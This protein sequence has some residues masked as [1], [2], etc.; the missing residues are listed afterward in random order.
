[1]DSSTPTKDT[2][3][4]EQ[5][6]FEDKLLLL[7]AQKNVLDVGGAG[8]FSKGLAKYSHW[9]KDSNFRSFDTPGVGA[10]IEGDIH[11]M[12]IESE[13]QDAVLCNAVL[14]HVA[15]PIRAVEEIHRILKTGGV[16]LV[17]VPSTYPYHGN[18]KYGD[19]WRFFEET[20]RY[21][22]KDFSSIEIVKQGGFFRAIILFLPFDKGVFQNVAIFL[23]KI[24]KTEEKR[25]TTRGYYIFVAK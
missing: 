20:L 23:D 16:A 12:P 7:A 21:M 11:H 25:H 13:S 4:K 3:L 6:F 14:E 8:R 1:M 19:Y 18:K 17:Q 24:F 2:R 10:D 9:F 15:D 5:I 22:F